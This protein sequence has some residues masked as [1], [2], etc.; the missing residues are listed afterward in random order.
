MAHSFLGHFFEWINLSTIQCFDLPNQVQIFL[1]IV[2]L[3]KKLVLLSPS[4]VQMTLL[5]RHQATFYFSNIE[6]LHASIVRRWVN[7]DIE[8]DLEAIPEYNL[9]FSASTSFNNDWVLSLKDLLHFFETYLICEMLLAICFIKEDEDLE[10]KCTH[11]SSTIFQKSY[12]SSQV[13]FSLKGEGGFSLLEANW[14]RIGRWSERPPWETHE[15][16]RK[17]LFINYSNTRNRSNVLEIVASLTRNF[18]H[19]GTIFVGFTSTNLCV[20][21]KQ[22][23]ETTLRV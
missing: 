13:W 12:S 19:V 5:L 8:R 4:F 21:K 17:F 9:S 23:K 22:R 18:F 3:V 11:V 10:F 2:E 1:M 16:I 14:K 6:F 7:S 15:F 20:F